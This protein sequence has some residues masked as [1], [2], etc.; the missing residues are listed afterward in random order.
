MDSAN[1]DAEWEFW[2]ISR[3]AM[4]IGLLS[5]FEVDT[6]RQPGRK[7]QYWGRHVRNLKEYTRE[8]IRR[9]PDEQKTA[10]VN[11]IMTLCNG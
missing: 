4:S 8:K 1:L 3:K 9:L 5:Q 2:N 6:L 10:D 7:A 11:E